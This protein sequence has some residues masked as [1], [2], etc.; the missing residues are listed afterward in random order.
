[1]VV[2]DNIPEYGGDC[3]VRWK[4]ASACLCRSHGFSN[5]FLVANFKFPPVSHS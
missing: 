5:L 4:D 1:M 2:L 3:Q